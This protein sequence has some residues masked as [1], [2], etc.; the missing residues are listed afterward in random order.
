MNSTVTS[1]GTGPDVLTLLSLTCY[2]R[3][4]KEKYGG[5]DIF[6][7][8]IK[9]AKST[10]TP[11]PWSA[12]AIR[13]HCSGLSRRPLFCCHMSGQPVPAM[14]HYVWCLPSLVGNACL[15][16]FIPQLGQDPVLSA[17]FTGMLA[18]PLT[19]SVFYNKMPNGFWHPSCR[20]CTNIVKAHEKLFIQFSL[21]LLQ[22]D[23]MH[24]WFIPENILLLKSTPWTSKVVGKR[25]I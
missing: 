4:V 24:V 7:W 17:Q 18:G 20:D 23:V 14:V 12:T 1:C 11:L 16:F 8:E 9:M 13:G 10:H 25:P 22:I 2:T 5:S 21:R 15:V 19:L 6:V 3:R